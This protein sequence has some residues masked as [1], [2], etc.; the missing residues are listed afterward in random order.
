M[1]RPRH[2]RK[3]AINR[4]VMTVINTTT[5]KDIDFS[6]LSPDAIADMKEL[7]ATGAEVL[8]SII[9]MGGEIGRLAKICEAVGC[10]S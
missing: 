10:E 9:E 6:H 1:S 7:Y 2:Y 8:P 5:S 3:Q 4:V